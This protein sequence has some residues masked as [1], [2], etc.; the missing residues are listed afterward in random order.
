MTGYIW[1]AWIVFLLLAVFY[2]ARARHPR[3]KP[4]AAYVMFVIVFTAAGFILF[5]ALSWGLAA[6]DR[7]ALLQRPLPAAGLLLVVFVPAFLLARWQ[8]RR[9]PMRAPR[10]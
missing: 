9:P 10:L 5:S 2:V 1:V 8:I 7:A 4:F 6:A 3:S